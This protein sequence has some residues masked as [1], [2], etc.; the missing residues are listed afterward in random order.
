MLRRRR[1]GYRGRKSAELH[2]EKYAPN[3][4]DRLRALKILNENGIKT[5]AFIGPLLPHFVAFE[6][7]LENIFKRLSG[8]GTKDIFVE[9]LNLSNYIKTRLIAEMKDKESQLIE[10]FY[11]S[12]SKEYREVLDDLVMKLVAKYNMNLLTGNTIFHKE[13]QQSESK[14]L[15]P[16]KFENS[17]SATM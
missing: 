12:Q 17:T 16:W 7:E 6:G 13:Y 11:V 4:T 15:E 1:G 10:K 2:F 9:H 8:A 5:Y 14:K 3:V